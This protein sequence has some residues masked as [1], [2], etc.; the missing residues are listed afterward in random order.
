MLISLR[1]NRERC[2]KLRHPPSL[3]SMASKVGACIRHGW[4][5]L[6]SQHRCSLHWH[7]N[8]IHLFPSHLVLHLY[9]ST[10]RDWTRLMLVRAAAK[11]CNSKTN[12]L[13]SVKRRFLALKHCL[14]NTHYLTLPGCK[15]RPN[16]Q[17]SARGVWCPLEAGFPLNCKLCWHSH[18]IQRGSCSAI[19]N[20][21]CSW[22][23]DLKTRNTKAFK[24]SVF[25]FATHTWVCMKIKCSEFTRQPL[26]GF[27]NFT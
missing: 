2:I 12:R 6:R 25:G 1:S 23:N 5:T 27:K 9:G 4:C 16:A 15:W 14:N 10:R 8:D 3:K 11:K 20:S 18:W 24:N 22:T 7:C 26:K 21:S 17:G 13:C 19:P